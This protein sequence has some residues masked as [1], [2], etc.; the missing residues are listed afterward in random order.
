MYTYN[1][2]FLF[3][4]Y[5]QLNADI[6]VPLTLSDDNKLYIRAL[7]KSRCD[8]N[9]LTLLPSNIPNLQVTDATRAEWIQRV[10][11]PQDEG[12]RSEQPCLI[13]SW[14]RDTVICYPSCA[15]KICSYISL[16]GIHSCKQPE[17]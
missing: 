17:S 6:I 15:M 8:V 3:F 5:I 10:A 12:V 11:P 7:V 9:A 13:L 4:I 1:I 14:V 16:K 2:Y